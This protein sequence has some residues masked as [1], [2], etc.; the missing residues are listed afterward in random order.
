[1]HG[2]RLPRPGL[3]LPRWMRR[4]EFRA[5]LFPATEVSSGFW[6]NLSNSFFMAVYRMTRDLQDEL[7]A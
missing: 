5:W 6:L 2:L 1:M 3:R 7:I 4:L